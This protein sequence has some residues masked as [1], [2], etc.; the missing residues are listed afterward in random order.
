MHSTRMRT[1][2]LLTDQGGIPSWH[3]YFHGAPSWN[4]PF[5]ESPP[6]RKAPLLR[7][8]VPQG[9]N[10]PPLW[11]DKHH[12][13]HYL[14]ATSFTGSKRVTLADYRGSSPGNQ[15]QASGGNHFVVDFWIMCT[16]F[17]M[18]LTQG[19]LSLA[20]CCSQSGGFTNFKL[21]KS[22]LSFCY[23]LSSISFW[24]KF[25]FDE[26]QLSISGAKIADI[27]RSVFT[28]QSS[29]FKGLFTQKHQ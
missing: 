20:F 6:L 15:P 29:P 17:I 12:L 13:K 1:A 2:R 21:T 3:P 23:S 27:H 8:A 4:T 11:T 26:E 14:S 10:P 16:L 7:M 9:W 25:N 22:K 24:A 19:D 5:H 18:G 28:F